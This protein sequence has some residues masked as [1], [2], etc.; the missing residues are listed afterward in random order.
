MVIWILKDLTPTTAEI[1]LDIRNNS[2]L[3]LPLGCIFYVYWCF[4]SPTKEQL[5]K[6]NISS[7]LFRNYKVDYHLA[8]SG[9]LCQGQGFA[10]YFDKGC[11]NN[12]RRREV[13]WV[14]SVQ[15]DRAGCITSWLAGPFVNYL[16]CSPDVCV[17]VCR[18]MRRRCL[19]SA[20]TFSQQQ[21]AL[22]L[23]SQWRRF[24]SDHGENEL[25]ADGHVDSNGTL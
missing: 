23:L 24:A 12:S 21:S 1:F 5:E 25:H 9:A 4:S 2:S 6:I 13:P 3:N 14:E 16:I 15:Q 22:K 19:P 11:V 18:F 8:A 17:W 10:Q 7:F 20:V